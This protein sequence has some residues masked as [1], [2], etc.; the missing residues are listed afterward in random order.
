MISNLADETDLPIAAYNVSGEYAMLIASA[1][2]GWGDL[3]GMV[4]ESTTAIVRAGADIVISYWAN[5]Y[6]EIFGKE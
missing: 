6:H 2:R 3:P 4:R 1:E 5:R